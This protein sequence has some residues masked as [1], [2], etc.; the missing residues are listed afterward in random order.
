M[1]HVQLG[2]A[3]VLKELDILPLDKNFRL[4]KNAIYLAKAAGIEVSNHFFMWHYSGRITAHNPNEARITTTT[5][6]Q[7]F[8]IIS[9]EIE[10]IERVELDDESKRKLAKLKPL[11]QTSPNLELLTSV[12]FLIEHKHPVKQL[13][14]ILANYEQ[15]YNE[16]QI[17]EAIAQLRNYSLLPKRS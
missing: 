1:N 11:I 10:E 9:S 3:L 8:D 5:L 2:M 4:K 13:Q 15:N 17:Q 6:S 12:H 16:E 7:D 14:K